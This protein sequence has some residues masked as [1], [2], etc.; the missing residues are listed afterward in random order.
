MCDSVKN[1]F[2]FSF[3]N[4]KILKLFNLVAKPLVQYKNGYLHFF[5]PT[6]VI[7][8]HSFPFDG[9]LGPLIRGPDVAY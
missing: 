4:M 8:M 1:V 5:I 2:F 6:R 3:W 9:V 7:N